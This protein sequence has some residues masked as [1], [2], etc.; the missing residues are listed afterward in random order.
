MDAHL[1]GWK[2]R[3]RKLQNPTFLGGAKIHGL[4]ESVLEEA[5]VIVAC[6][7]LRRHNVPDRIKARAL[8]I[9]IARKKH[10]Q[11]GQGPL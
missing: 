5:V 6:G 3:Q 2:T 9:R 8:G 4:V 10:G 7:R 11:L 1:W